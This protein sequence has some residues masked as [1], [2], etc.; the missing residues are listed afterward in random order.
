[1]DMS[2]AAMPAKYGFATKQDEADPLFSKYREYRSVM[3][4]LMIDCESFKDWKMCYLR[5]QKEDNIAKHKE[6]KNFQKWM[7]EN[8]GGARKCPA[9]C[10]PKN[11]EYW[12]NGGRW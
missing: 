10:F 2:K 8:Q 3:S 4:K 6:F 9:G 12:L 1:M 7:F 5:N 11:F